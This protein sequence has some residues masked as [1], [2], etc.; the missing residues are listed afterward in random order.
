MGL[1]S[2]KTVKE[3]LAMIGLE[4]IFQINTQ[5]DGISLPNQNCQNNDDNQLNDIT[6][7]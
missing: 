4:Q 2:R 1:V 3:S 6:T 7:E 5:T